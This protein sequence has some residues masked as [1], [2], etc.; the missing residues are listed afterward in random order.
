MPSQPPLP[1]I[2]AQALKE[3]SSLKSLEL[4]RGLLRTDNRVGARRLVAKFEKR[5]AREEKENQRLE[6]LWVY[7]REGRSKGFQLIAGVDE[8][9]RGPLA[10][11]VVAAAV[12]LPHD[13]HLPGVDDSKKLTAARREELFGVITGSAVA[14]CLPSVAKSGM[15]V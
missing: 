1:E 15:G 7:E 14:R 9:G 4:V 12:I 13:F 5:A 11:P 8:A 2:E 10:G 3:T 6:K